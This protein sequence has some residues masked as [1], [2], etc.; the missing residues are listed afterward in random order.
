[1]G[2]SGIDMQTASNANMFAVGVS[3]GYRPEEELIAE[4]AKYVLSNPLDLIQILQPV[5][6]NILT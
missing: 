5:G 6:V 2:D 4:G 1:M 3:W